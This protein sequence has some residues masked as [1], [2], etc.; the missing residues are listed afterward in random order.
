[1][2]IGGLNISL[3]SEWGED[4][5][6]YLSGSGLHLPGVKLESLEDSVEKM[7][8]EESFTKFSIWK[9]VNEVV[10]S[11]RKHSLWGS[12]KK[13]DSHRLSNLVSVNTE[14]RVI[15]D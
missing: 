11:P 4:L 3:D 8:H 12:T 7:A 1:M 10:S 6:S 13:Q 5:L 9:F 15:K 14:A 2:K